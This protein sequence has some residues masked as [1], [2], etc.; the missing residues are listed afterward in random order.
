MSLRRGELYRIRT[1]VTDP[2][3]FRVVAV[4]SRDGFLSVRYSTAICAPVYSHLTGLG[5]EVA[6]G[7]EAGLKHDSW[8]RCD[9]LMSIRRDRLTDFVGSLSEAASARLDRALAVALEI[10]HL[11]E[12][13]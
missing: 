4:V 11:L 2:K 8:I 12:V 5:T 13:Q 7:A 1:S 3:K 9:D 6:I 10:D